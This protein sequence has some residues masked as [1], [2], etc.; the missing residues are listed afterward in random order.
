M[1]AIRG[2]VVAFGIVLMLAATAVHPRAETADRAVV[3]AFLTL[4]VGGESDKPK[5][6][7]CSW[8]GF[9]AALVDCGDE[10]IWR[11]PRGSP[12]G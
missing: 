10:R 7:S 2:L 11:D 9:A 8:S 6:G 3:R 1:P 4:L 5:S 12:C